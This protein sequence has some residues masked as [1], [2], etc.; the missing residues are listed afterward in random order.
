MSEISREMINHSKTSL[1]RSEIN[2]ARYLARTDIGDTLWTWYGLV[3]K[4]RP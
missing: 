3:A 4:A 1:N 2:V